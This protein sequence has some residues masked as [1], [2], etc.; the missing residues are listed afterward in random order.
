ML[1]WEGFNYNR[2]NDYATWRL[3]QPEVL[4]GCGFRRLNIE[5]WAKLEPLTNTTNPRGGPGN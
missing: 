1:S 5:A 2:R 3:D 4:P